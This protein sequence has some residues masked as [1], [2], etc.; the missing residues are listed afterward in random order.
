MAAARRQTA[1]SPLLGASLVLVGH[2]T[3]AIFE[4]TRAWRLHPN[5]RNQAMGMLE[6]TSVPAIMEETLI[7]EYTVNLPTLLPRALTYSTKKGNCAVDRG[8]TIRGMSVTFG[9]AAEP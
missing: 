4:E 7:R 1:R 2:V 6:V 5:T 8:T 9:I 3:A